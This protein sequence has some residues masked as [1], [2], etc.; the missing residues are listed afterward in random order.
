ML[1]RFIK[2]LQFLDEEYQIGETA[3]GFEKAYT[4]CPIYR[5]IEN[6]IGDRHNKIRINE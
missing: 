1:D 4:E 5:F 2:H 6:K 3:F